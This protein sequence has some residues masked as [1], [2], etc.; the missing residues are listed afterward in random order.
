LEFGFANQ[1]I[2]G[3]FE[4]FDQDPQVALWLGHGGLRDS[5]WCGLRELRL[6]TLIFAQER[7][8]VGELLGRGAE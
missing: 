7:A 3:E 5:L 8:G 1:G 4:G 6:L 2:A